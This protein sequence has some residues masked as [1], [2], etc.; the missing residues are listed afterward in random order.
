MC[1]T[2]IVAIKEHLLCAWLM[3]TLGVKELTE[4][5]QLYSGLS[6]FIDEETE[7]GRG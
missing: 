1:I 3:L 5:Q 6:H 2:R 7:A 4:S